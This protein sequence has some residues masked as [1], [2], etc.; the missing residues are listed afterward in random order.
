VFTLIILGIT[1]LT[2]LIPPFAPVIARVLKLETHPSSYLLPCFAAALF[3]VSFYLPDI[4]ISASTTTF[5]QHL[6]GGGMYS[7]LLYIYFKRYLEWKL[8][9][10]CDLII[11]FAWVSAL[12]VINKLLEFS[13][14]SLHLMTLDMSDAYWDLLANTVGAYTLYVPAIVFA[15]LHSLSARRS[16]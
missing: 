13:L 3:F 12:G 9:P 11:L 4:N 15:Y 5:Q 6:V 7:A 1:I 10:I 8:N 16:K 14:S 2:A